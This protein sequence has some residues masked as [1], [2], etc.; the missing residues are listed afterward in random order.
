M[1]ELGALCPTYDRPETGL[2]LLQEAITSV[3]LTAGQDFHIALNCAAQEIFD[4]VR[5]ACVSKF[6]GKWACCNTS[7]K[8]LNQW[9]R[10]EFYVP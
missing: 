5:F 8:S 9:S 1:N 4:Y 3:G 6:V 2:D 7:Q 10:F